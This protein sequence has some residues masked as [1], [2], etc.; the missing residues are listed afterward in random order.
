MRIGYLHNLI[1]ISTLLRHRP[2]LKNVNMNR[3]VDHRM[4][5]ADIEQPPSRTW[6]MNSRILISL[7]GINQLGSDLLPTENSTSQ[8]HNW[9]YLSWELEILTASSISRLIK[10]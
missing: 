9:P 6:I 4:A 1:P 8:D 3:Y 10:H 2:Y 5:M 7:N